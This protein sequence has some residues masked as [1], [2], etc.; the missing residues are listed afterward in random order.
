MAQMRHSSA[1]PGRNRSTQHRPGGTERK[2]HFRGIERLCL[3]GYSRG[4]GL[5]G[6]EGEQALSCTPVVR[7]IPEGTTA[8]TKKNME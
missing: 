5:S 4:Q 8:I 6:G 3:G 7:A 1:R 2:S